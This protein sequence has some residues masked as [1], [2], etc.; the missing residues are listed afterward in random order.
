[1]MLPAAETASSV[2]MVMNVNGYAQLR[3]VTICNLNSI[4][5]GQRRIELEGLK[6]TSMP[7]VAN[8]I[9]V[10]ILSRQQTN[11]FLKSVSS[12]LELYYYTVNV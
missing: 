9:W 7:S 5:G 6:R 1:M 2:G 10:L 3:A 11:D 4:R 12:V 8:R